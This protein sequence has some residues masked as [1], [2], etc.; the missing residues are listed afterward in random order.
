MHIHIHTPWM[1]RWNAPAVKTYIDVMYTD[2]KSYIV[3]IP[4]IVKSNVV[5]IPTIV[6]SLAH[7]KHWHIHIASMIHSDVP[8]VKHYVFFTSTISHSPLYIA[9]NITIIA[10]FSSIRT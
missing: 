1:A 4:T 8:S 5:I 2:V 3:V 9:P 10:A 7:T 6:S